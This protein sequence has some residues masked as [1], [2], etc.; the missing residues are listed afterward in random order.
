MKHELKTIKNSGKIVFFGSGPVAARCL[1]LLLKKWEIEAVVTK[2]RPAHHRG[3]VPVISLAE[4]YNI[5]ILTVANRAELDH[6]MSTHTFLSQCSVLIDFGIIVSQKVINIFPLGIVNSHFSLLPHLRG[7]DPITFSIL[8]GAKK[9]GVS[10]MVLDKGMDT[11][12]LLA[13][14]SLHLASNETAPTLTERLIILSDELINEYLLRYMAGKLEPKSQ[15]HPERATYSRKLIKADGMIDWTKT[16]QQLEREIRAF[17][18]W[19]KSR[20]KIGQINI[21]LR[22][23]TIESDL[24]DKKPGEY[25]TMSNKMIVQTGEGALSITQLQPIGKKEMPVQAFL[26]GYRSKL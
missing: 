21:I 2:P 14:R 6:V 25:L 24:K 17:Y 20:A 1:K 18:E 19:P 26:A 8:E 23:A 13:Y 10:L 4:S 9:T 22:A 15:P 11:G 7:A 16:A 12:K 5:P 3:D